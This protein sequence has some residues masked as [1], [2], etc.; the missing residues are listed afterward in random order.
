[1]LIDHV[2]IRVKELEKMKRFFLSY[3]NCKANQK[4]HNPC[5]GFSSY[6]ISFPAGGR[7]ELIHIE[8]KDYT[9]MDQAVD[10]GYSHLAIAVGTTEKVD[11][12]TQ[13]I[14]NDGFELMS[15]PRQTGDGYYESVIIGPEGIPFEIMALPDYDLIP[16]SIS[17]AQEILILQKECYLSEAEIYNN[18]EIQPLTQTFQEVEDEL[19]EWAAYKLVHKGRIIGS[20]RCK[21]SECTCQIGKLIVSPSYQNM[22]FGKL[23][24][25]TAENHFEEAKHLELFTG[26]RSEKNLTLYRSLGYEVTN[27]EVSTCDPHL[28]YLEKS[29]Q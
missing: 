25:E 20:V 4:Y 22:G 27:K 21:L 28:V 13:R 16:A 19:N 2:A 17:D 9:G 1:M 6:F 3:F 8:S 12:I 18:Y 11:R 14:E 23:L 29:K 7:V 5:K 15:P 26:N 10:F 24:M